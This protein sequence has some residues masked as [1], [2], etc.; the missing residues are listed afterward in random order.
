LLWW[1]ECDS[2]EVRKS[3]LL[4]CDLIEGKPPESTVGPSPMASIVPSSKRSARPKTISYKAG[5]TNV[6]DA[7][8]GG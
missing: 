3:M 4:V 1:S 8:G 7:V 6:K 5:A 2:R